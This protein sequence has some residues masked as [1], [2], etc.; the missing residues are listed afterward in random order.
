MSTPSRQTGWGAEENL[1]SFIIKQLDYLTK[2]A[3]NSGGVGPDPNLDLRITN[4][5]NNELKVTYFEIISGTSGSITIPT[6]TTIN[7]EE[8]GLSGNAVLSKIDIANKPIFQ[9]PLTA[10]GTIVTASLDPITGDW[11]ATGEYTDTN[12]ALIYSLKLK[13]LNYSNLDYDFIID[14]TSNNITRTSELINDGDDGVSHFISLND[15]PSNIV[16]YPTTATSSISG[17]YKLVSSITDPSY[18][19]TAVDVTT[20]AITTTSQLISSLVTSPNL[21]VGNPGVFNITTIG[22]IRRTSGSG[23][24]RFYF[25]IYKRTSGGTETL[26]AT[27]DSTIPVID[28]GTY[29]EFSATALWNDGIFSPTDMVVMKFYGSRISG[30]SSPTYQFQFGGTKPVRTLVPIP[31]NVIPSDIYLDDIVD[32]LISTPLNDQV[33]AYE[34]ASSLWKNKTISQGVSLSREEF[35]FTG[36]QDF[37]LAS[38]PSSI[39]AVFVN[40]QELN[41][42]QYSNATTTLTILNTLEIIE[43][44]P[45]KVNILYTPT[46]AGILEYYTKAQ[47]DAF[48]YEEKHANF[49][50]VN[51]VTDL[52]DA[53]SGVITLL[54]GNTYLFLKHIDLA[55]GRLVCGTDTVI[56]GWSSENCSISSTGLSSGTALITS[57]NSLPIRNISFTHALVFDLQGDGVTTALDWFGVNLLN[58]A[59][60]GTIKNYTN[61]VAGDSA[62]L[63]SGG[64]IFDGTLGTS[65]F[66]NCLFDTAPGTTAITILP[67]C[68]ISRRLRIIYS[69]FVILSGETGVNCS[70]SA[71]I[72]DEKYILDTVNFSGGGT[73]T[74]GFDATSNKSLF[75]NCVGIT[76]TSTRGFIHML[77]NTTA[78]AI[79]STT[80]Y[81][82]AA[83]TTTA[84][85]TNSKFT[86]P[87]SNRLT[88]TGAFSQSFFVTLNCNVRTSVSTQNVNIVIAKNGTII[89]ESE[90]T[91]LCAAGSTPSFGGT[92]VVVE[93]TTND[94]IELFVRNTSSVNNVTVVD[95]NMNIVKI[96]V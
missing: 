34:T 44:V 45:D 50:E 56:V 4:L 62:L 40:G 78:T 72:G 85:A 91:I 20:G 36:S 37:T 71:T 73:Y 66:S 18:N 46:T 48:N 60:G 82:K 23:E 94:Y 47:I 57:T 7:E 75:A 88:Y 24:A 90:M 70:T 53:V 3:Y 59:S 89:S 33:L 84:M 29:N 96:P 65:A 93:L 21:L 6:S 52:P 86:T 68:T 95:L 61:F 92:Q 87:A 5:E 81:F 14:E 19:T 83:G 64:F 10:T 31:L 63:N 25:E 17:Y 2:V 67:T 9:S 27:S 38:T 55:G 16:L 49:V 41:S 58:C 32:V 80:G 13:T 26:I 74:S 79:S 12:V 22:N 35:T 1:L 77:D 39:Y 42:S 15:L 28:G 30:G 76:N 51:D 69:S 54:D 11:V 8:F 43:G